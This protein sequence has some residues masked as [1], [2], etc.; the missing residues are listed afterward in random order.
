MSQPS[1]SGMSAPTRQPLL[2][3]LPPP[4]P[5]ADSDEADVDVD[6]ADAS[7][8]DDSMAAAAAAA[9]M[10]WWLMDIAGWLVR[11]DGLMC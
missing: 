7:D 4:P 5:T 1:G 11:V 10:L 8:V 2:P 9:A 3:L 6:V